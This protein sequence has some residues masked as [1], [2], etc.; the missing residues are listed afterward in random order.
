MEVALRAMNLLAAFS[1]FLRAPQ[2]D[3]LMLKSSCKSSIHMA[4]TSSAIWNS[5]TSRRAIIIWLTSP[6]CFGLA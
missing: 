4:R 3:E 2:M 1:L 5:R 6:D